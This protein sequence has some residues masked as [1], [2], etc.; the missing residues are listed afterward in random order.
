MAFSAP[1]N[2]VFL[3]PFQSGSVYVYD[4]ETRSRIAAIRVED[5]AGVVGLAVS[6]D[7]TSLY[8]VDGNVRSRLRRFDT[9]TWKE[10]WSRE[11]PDRLLALG[12]TQVLHVTEDN[13]WALIRTQP[14]GAAGSSA[15]RVFDVQ[16]RQFA[17]ASLA[18][19]HCSQPLFASARDGALAAVCPGFLELLGAKAGEELSPARE[20]PIGIQQPAATVMAHDGE[21]AF[22]LGA[23]TTDAPWELERVAL[24]PEPRAESWNLQNILGPSARTEEEPQP[25][26]LA[27]DDRGATLAIGYGP[28]AWLVNAPAMRLKLALRMSGVLAAAQ[29]SRDGSVLYTLQRDD[30]KHAMLLG[31]TGV[32][33]GV[34][35]ES[36]L[37]DN[38]PLTPVVSRFALLTGG[39]R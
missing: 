38:L 10:D 11:F 13:R 29:F 1:T 6:T 27:S 35:K 7:G 33:S 34:P 9:K 12:A 20:L 31:R 39:N 5:G 36:I 26:L 18:V 32:E 21:A 25:S 2:V 37:L 3:A 30:T 4:V 17:A 23:R 19:R 8:L 24:R 28:R 15:V 22:V 16:K 14:V